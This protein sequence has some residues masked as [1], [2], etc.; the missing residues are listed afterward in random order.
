MHSQ[1]PRTQGWIWSCALLWRC[2]ERP[3]DR[4]ENRAERSDPVLCVAG[5]HPACGLIVIAGPSARKKRWQPWPVY[6][7][8]SASRLSQ[9]G[10][11]SRHVGR[12]TKKPPKMTPKMTIQGLGYFDA[13]PDATKPMVALEASLGHI[14]I[15]NPLHEVLKI[16]ASPDQRLRL[17]SKHASARRASGRRFVA[18]A[19]WSDR[20][21]GK[22]PAF[23][24]KDR[25]APGGCAA[26]T[27]CRA[28]SGR[29]QQLS[30]LHHRLFATR[31]GR[32][33]PDHHHHQCM[34]PDGGRVS[35][36]A[37]GGGRD[38]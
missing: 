19:G 37:S 31:T 24:T 15:S 14:F 32:T 25:A 38:T 36:P 16:R 7:R 29:R 18:N 13:I 33:R 6:F 23:N 20:M 21:A 9:T 3:D 26:L 10:S 1:R 34:D 22:R 5:P 17:L 8:V 35:Q 4:A 11:L 28:T 27:P 2:P 30:R 12:L